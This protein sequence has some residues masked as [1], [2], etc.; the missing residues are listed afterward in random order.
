MHQESTPVNT[1]DMHGFV[2]MGRETL[3]LDHLP[4][5]GMENH[6]YQFLVQA[7]I[8]DEAMAAYL[9]A[10]EENPD[11]PIILGNLST[12]LFTIPQAVVGEVTSFQADLFVG[13]PEDPETDTP[14]VHNVTVN[15]TRIVYVR[16][17]AEQMAF[18]S[19]LTYLLFG[20]G[21]EAFL[22]HYQTKAPDF[23][24]I[25]ELAQ[26]PEWLQSTSLEM[27]VL[28][29]FPTVSGATSVTSN[30]LIDPSYQVQYEGE[31]PLYPITLKKSLFWSEIE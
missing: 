4:M 25:V 27:G 6:R 7:S 28:I 23:Q 24:H 20:R 29:N 31:S 22:S 10:S 21:Q 15:L 3:F 19:S 13:L 17:Y 26:V 14:L 5:F 8:P 11:T 2:M 16:H 1:P 18:P 9:R 30:P 12:D